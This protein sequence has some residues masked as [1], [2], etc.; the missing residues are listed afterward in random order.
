M[1]ALSEDSGAL[2]PVSMVCG[3]AL[4]AYSTHTTVRKITRLLL[5]SCCSSTG[6]VEVDAAGSTGTT[7][8]TTIVVRSVCSEGTGVEVTD[9]KAKVLELGDCGMQ[10]EGRFLSGGARK[11]VDALSL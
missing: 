9:I 4:P 2:S 1:S 6:K 11:L 3:C 5:S 10:S 8:T 7:T